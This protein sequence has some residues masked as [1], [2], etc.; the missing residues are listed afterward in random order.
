MENKYLKETVM[1]LIP[2]GDKET[3]TTDTDETDKTGGGTGNT[4]GD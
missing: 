3:V 2:D 1:N 4:G